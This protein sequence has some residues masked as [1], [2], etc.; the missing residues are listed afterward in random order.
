MSEDDDA[1]A[2]AEAV[3]RYTGPVTQCPPGKPRASN[4]KVVKVAKVLTVVDDATH[5]LQHHVDDVPVK[6]LR[7]E[8]RRQRMERAKR[9]RIADRNAPLLER[10][11]EH[12]R[13]EQIGRK[14]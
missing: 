13:V 8:R 2:M 6:D 12:D 11:R 7:E 1:K 5:W 3:A 14:R 9:Q 10:I 4:K